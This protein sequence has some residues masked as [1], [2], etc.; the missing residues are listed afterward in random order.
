MKGFPEELK[1]LR[2]WVGYRLVPVEDGGKPKKNQTDDEQQ[3]DEAVL[4]EQRCSCFCAQIK[5][6]HRVHQTKL[7][8]NIK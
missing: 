8:N 4:Q 3:Y 2:R 5:P 6:Q 7:I 1:K